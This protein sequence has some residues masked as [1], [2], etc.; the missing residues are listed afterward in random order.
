MRKIAAFLLLSVLGSSAW[1][2]SIPPSQVKPGTFQGE[3]YTFPGTVAA[4]T[5][6]GVVSPCSF[7]GAT[8]D[9]QIMNAKA[10]LPS[11]GGTIDA[12]C[13][14]ATTQS[15][16]SATVDLNGVQGSAYSLVA[17][18]S[19]VFVP[20]GAVLIGSATAAATF[21]SSSTQVSLNSVPDN[22]QVGW[23]IAGTGIP[24]G[25][26]VV[27]IRSPDIVI[28]NS[29][30]SR[31]SGITVSFSGS[32]PMF[33]AVV[34]SQIHGVTT[35]I[36]AS[37]RGDVVL[38]LTS[39][40]TNNPWAGGTTPQLS[41]PILDTIT[42]F[43]ANNTIAN[44]VA[45]RAN[46]SSWGAVAWMRV[47]DVTSYGMYDTVLLYANT[48]G[49]A[50]GIWVDKVA[51]LGSKNAVELFST[52]CVGSCAS[53]NQQSVANNM[54]THVSSEASGPGY[55]RLYL[56]GFHVN[57][58][59]F[60]QLQLFDNSGVSIQMDCGATG[61]G[62]PYFNYFS[63]AVS[64]RIIECSNPDRV[65]S[66]N[67]VMD[68]VT[69]NYLAQYI[70]SY[71]T[72]TSTVL[73]G[74]GNKAFAANDQGSAGYAAYH[75]S[76][77]G[78]DDWSMG[79]NGDTSLHLHDAGTANRD[80]MVVAPG[81]I[82]N[83]PEGIATS[84]AT[85]TGALKAAATSNSQ[86]VAIAVQ[87]AAGTGATVSCHA[88]NTCTPSYGSLSFNAGTRPSTGDQVCVSWST[89]FDHRVIP[90]VAGYDNTAN[91]PDTNVVGDAGVSDASHFC[92]TTP[93]ALIAGH[94][95]TINYIA[96]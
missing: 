79:H 64:G 38:Y 4:G 88:G 59:T 57:D 32:L 51:G 82:P 61:T 75:W 30:T 9:V 12:R 80:A 54:L 36:P 44:C 35:S 66:L 77:A 13:Y 18:H 55:G 34:Q 94:L 63:G 47:N 16:A 7:P 33:R 45:V 42:C 24:A 68:V 43:G 19:T 37:Y 8:A 87:G 46:N 49:W 27:A 17:D 92:V 56:H 48:G 21:S 29:T 90:I 25:T 91:R 41:G 73:T 81:G 40:S 69:N 22:L 3:I 1:A 70:S 74:N 26:T 14:G 50:N 84:A 78:T 85:V 52:P 39:S 67:T 58:N 5:I 10:A 31:Q 89:A 53:S 20:G 65:L 23:T 15:I 60:D 2:Q 96:Q 76:H 83:F 62:T 6:N 71:N 11:A 72:I 86:T 95:Y 93:V 28:S